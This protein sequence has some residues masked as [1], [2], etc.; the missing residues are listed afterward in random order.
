MCK[1]AQTS[2]VEAAFDSGLDS[3]GNGGRTHFTTLHSFT[4][5]TK[6]PRECAPT[7]AN[8]KTRN[9]KPEKKQ[10]VADRGVQ[11]NTHTHKRMHARYGYSLTAGERARISLLLPSSRRGCRVRSINI[12]F[13]YTRLYQSF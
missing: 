3:N 5:H 4:A 2:T 6:I 11:T 8:C 12:S 13:C 1:Q 7:K 10:K 9:Q